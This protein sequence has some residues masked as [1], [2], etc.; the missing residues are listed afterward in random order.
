MFN[1]PENFD[2]NNDIHQIVDS[3]NQLNTIANNIKSLEC[4]ILLFNIIIAIISGFIAYKKGYNGLLWSLYC[5]STSIFG[6]IQVIL[7]TNYISKEEKQ[8]K[9]NKIIGI[10]ILFAIIEIISL[11]YYL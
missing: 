11:C 7:L 6:F 9:N 4:S 5:F 3:L 1:N 2:N 8:I 10:S